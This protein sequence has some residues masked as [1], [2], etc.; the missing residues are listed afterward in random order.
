MAL[1]KAD[2]KIN[3]NTNLSWSTFNWIMDNVTH[4]SQQNNTASNVYESAVKVYT[5]YICYILFIFI[6]YIFIVYSQHLVIFQRQQNKDIPKIVY[7]Q[8]HIL[9]NSITRLLHI[10]QYVHQYHLQ[11]INKEFQLRLK[12]Y[13]TDTT[14]Q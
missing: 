7:I 13:I 6:I 8:N 4:A 5:P 12:N 9:F 14:P 1:Y 2:F 10:L 3:K 11:L